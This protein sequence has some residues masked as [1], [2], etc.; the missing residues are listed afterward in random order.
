[1]NRPLAAVVLLAALAAPSRGAAFVWPNVPDEIARAL[2]NDDVGERRMA[3]ARL[4]ELPAGYAIPLVSKALGDSDIDVRLVAARAAVELRVPGSGERV[5]SWLGEGDSRLR[6]MACEV[7]RFSAASTAVSPLERALGDANADVRAAAATTL[8]VLGAH[9]AVPALLGHLDDPSPEVRTALVLALGRIG[10]VRAVVPLLGK[11]QDGSHEVRR[12]TVRVLG[13]LGD[14]KASSA[15][16]LALRDKVVAVQ[17]EAIDSLGRLK[18][19][20]ATSALAPL[21]LDR[22]NVRVRSAAVTALG[23]I[24]SPAALDA[25]MAALPADDAQS[26]HS[27][28]R[29]A[30]AMMGAAAVPRL[31]SALSSG[32]SGELASGASLVLGDLGDSHN[33]R[34]IVD[35]MQRGQVPARV[36]LLALSKLGDRSA[37][38]S[39]LELLD[40]PSGPVRA[41]AVDAA[42]QLLEPS[43]KQGSAVDP[44]VAQLNK[45]Q[46]TLDDRVALAT[47]LG[48][49]GSERAAPTLTGL[50]ASKNLR[51]RLAALAA[52]GQI[53]AAGQDKL[54]L[55]ALRDDEPDVRLTAALSLSKTAD[56]NASREL[57]RRLV[58]A[59]EQDRMALGIALSGA[60]SR[61]NADDIATAVAQMLPTVRE[62]LRDVLLESLGRMRSPASSA[63]LAAWSNQAVS[64]DDR[65]KIAE[66]LAARPEQIDL[67]RKLL[68]DP[69]PSVQANAVW[70]LGFVGDQADLPALAKLVSH[71]D[72]AVAGN[73]IGAMGRMIARGKLRD[74][75]SLCAAVD[76]PRT[77]VRANALAALAVAHQRCGNGERERAAL[78]SDLS[79]VVRARAAALLQSVTSSD[80]PA[81]TRALR[82]CLFDDRNGGVAAQ[83][84]EHPPARA[85]APSVVEPVLVFVI[86]EG[87]TA[88]VSRAPFA[89]VLADGIM[90]LGVTDRRGAVFEPV[91]ARGEVSLAVPATLVR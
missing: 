78:L 85:N 34:I 67:T 53:G 36:G 63:A 70:S 44:I 50:A 28:V 43:Q 25:L 6:L 61:V 79:P 52:L 15:L 12:I 84:K 39:V 87:Q 1:M 83:C 16:M 66:T 29:D 32:T 82:R 35:A 21:T 22:S 3:A 9:E 64:A 57:L 8:G 56:A 10:D 18:A 20:D 30:L 74:A 81:D 51:L 72:V 71:R 27:P 49:T 24:G 11:V 60:M 59:S 90:R 47:L 54:L 46:T 38:P 14:S 23:R 76:E 86:P 62:S 31:T 2:S 4:R 48:R 37:L 42:T 33:T 55:D 69:D 17:I 45:P 77:Y 65:R 19:S 80:A 91:A 40:S 5:V 89:L 58:A 26:A 7:I 88:P 13:D 73:A 68:S 41:A 75:T